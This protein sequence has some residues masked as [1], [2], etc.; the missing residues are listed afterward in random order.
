MTL[1]LGHPSLAHARRLMHSREGYTTIDIVPPLMT[2]YG[3]LDVRREPLA[4][5]KRY[6]DIYRRSLPW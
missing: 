5:E 4:P 1:D 2:P 3:A 6:P